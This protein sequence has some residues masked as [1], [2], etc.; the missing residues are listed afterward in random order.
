MV[1]DIS[2]TCV[3]LSGGPFQLG[4]HYIS[5]RAKD[6][7]GRW[8]TQWDTFGPFEVTDCN[9]NGIIDACESV[10]IPAALLARF[11]KLACSSM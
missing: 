1:E 2:A 3:T 10:C 8:S 7:A 6:C 5:I 4:Q 11:F 9:D